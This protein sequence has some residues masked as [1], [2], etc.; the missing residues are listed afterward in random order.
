MKK[1]IPIILALVATTAIVTLL[2]LMPRIFKTVPA[3][4]EVEDNHAY[5]VTYEVV[6]A[7]ELQSAEEKPYSIVGNDLYVDDV[8]YKDGAKNLNRVETPY[9]AE[10]LYTY[11]ASVT[12][13]YFAGECIL[14]VNVYRDD[15][16]YTDTYEDWCTSHNDTLS[17]L[18]STY[19]DYPTCEII[20]MPADLSEVIHIESCKSYTYKKGFTL[21][22]GTTPE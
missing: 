10:E 12:P 3:E 20:L 13:D 2:I 15:P 7:T 14:S 18:I 6:D 9:T 1:Y 21:L 8:V 16:N 17:E 11:I 19:D 4:I 5:E 22:D